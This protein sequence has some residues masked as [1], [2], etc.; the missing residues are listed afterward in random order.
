MPLASRQKNVAELRAHLRTPCRAT[1]D[2]RADF[3]RRNRGD[4]VRDIVR[5][6]LDDNVEASL[7]AQERVFEIAE[8]L[9]PLRGEV[10]AARR[11]L[12]TP[13]AGVP[14]A[15]ATLTSMPAPIDGVLPDLVVTAQRLPQI[16]AALGFRVLDNLSIRAGNFVASV[17]ERI[18]E[19]LDSTPGARLALRA[20]DIGLA[21]AG[22]PARFVLGQISGAAI[23]QVIEVLEGR[24]IRAGHAMPQAAA[25]AIGAPA[26]AQFALTGVAGLR[27]VA[28]RI[29]GRTFQEQATRGILEPVGVREN[30]RS[31]T[32]RVRGRLVT[33]IPDAMGRPVG[34]V[35][36]KNPHVTG[37]I[38]NSRQLEAQLE[39]AARTGQPYNLVV[40]PATRNISPTLLRNIEAHNRQYGGGV[41][42]YDPATDALTPWP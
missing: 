2:A 28:N 29:A 11:L 25:G 7:A 40:S 38:R 26:L 31:V 8:Q 3:L 27:L 22:G 39:H 13:S 18:N 32:E 23:G 24:F 36:F 16:S 33:T 21:I 34:V 6:R 12:S 20:L 5:V 37:T 30:F 19:A 4:L 41:Y 17:G 15:E 9:E 14:V 1:G 42:R 35:E 10:E